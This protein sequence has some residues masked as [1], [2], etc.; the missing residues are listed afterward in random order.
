VRAWYV[1][2]HVVAQTAGGQGLLTVGAGYQLLRDRLAVEA[3]LGYVPA[4][5]L[6]VVGADLPGAFVGGAFVM[7][8][9]PAS[10]ACCGSTR[11]CITN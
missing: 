2:R 6:L 8:Y 7:P 9:P 4:R 1:P 3:L 5:V 11:R 10:Q